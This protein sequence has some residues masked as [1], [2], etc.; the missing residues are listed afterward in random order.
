MTNRILP[1]TVI[2]TLLAWGCASPAEQPME[3]PDDRESA[4]IENGEGGAAANPCAGKPDASDGGCGLGYDPDGNVT[5]AVLTCRGGQPKSMMTCEFNEI[6]VQQNGLSSCNPAACA[7]GTP[8]RCEGGDYWYCDNGTWTRKFC[9]FADKVCN[10]NAVVP[11]AGCADT[12]TCDWTNTPRCA[13]AFDVEVC[14]NGNVDLQQC[15]GGAQCYGPTFGCYQPGTAG[16]DCGFGWFPSP[17]Q[18]DGWDVLLCQ[19]NYETGKW[20]KKKCPADSHCAYDSNRQAV[21]QDMNL[22]G[23]DAISAE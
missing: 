16:A 7:P 12:R 11:E 3:R 15:Q 13:G 10:P 19:M 14:V 4:V 5:S 22:P 18:C 21:C 9:R 2:S 23:S 1:T 17:P 6:C 20:V 8:G